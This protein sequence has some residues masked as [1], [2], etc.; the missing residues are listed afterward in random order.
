M[1]KTYQQVVKIQLQKGNDIAKT[2]VKQQWY[3][4]M[5]IMKPKSLQVNNVDPLL[6]RS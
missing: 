2:I 3:L 4:G 1:Y 5:M 6:S